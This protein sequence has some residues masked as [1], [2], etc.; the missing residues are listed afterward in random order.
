MT[1]SPSRLAAVLLVVTAAGLLAGCGSVRGTSA[2]PASNRAA[3]VGAA[4]PAQGGWVIVDCDGNPLTRPASFVL[5]RADP[6]DA[7][8]PVHGVALGAQAAAPGPAT[9]NLG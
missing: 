5:T 9:I 2:A 1:R 7:P 8:G 6:N 4:V 3:G